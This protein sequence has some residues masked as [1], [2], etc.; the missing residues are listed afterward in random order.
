MRCI[1]NVTVRIG[2]VG[3]T[4]EPLAGIGGTN[5]QEG[6]A[7]MMNAVRSIESVKIAMVSWES[8]GHTRK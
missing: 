4:E 3:E 7:L 1:K 6:I 5:G 8:A 2:T